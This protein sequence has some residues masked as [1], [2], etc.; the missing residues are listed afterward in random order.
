MSLF[1]PLKARLSYNQ[2]SGCLVSL[3]QPNF[4][5]PSRRFWFKM[6]QTGP[7]NLPQ[8]NTGRS[9]DPDL[10]R[11]SANLYRSSPGPGRARGHGEWVGRQGLCQQP[12]LRRSVEPRRE[13][14]RFRWASGTPGA[15]SSLQGASQAPAETGSFPRSG[16]APDYGATTLRRGPSSDLTGN[17]GPGAVTCPEAHPEGAR[18]A[19][20]ILVGL[21]TETR[22]ESAGCLP[23]PLRGY[24]T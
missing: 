10:Y 16:K 17:R 24:A 11:P 15:K 4:G 14:A 1:G 3:P 20:R 2:I 13:Q 19:E 23:G 8:A 21:R 7:V 5:R 9:R 22:L 12:P 18:S 6:N